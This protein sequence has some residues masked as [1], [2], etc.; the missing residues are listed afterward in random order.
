MT[1]VVAPST[2][3][4]AALALAEAQPDVRAAASALRQH[5][6]NARIVVVDAFD[7]RAEPKAAAGAKV[8]LWYGASDGHCWTVTTDPAQAAGLF[9]AAT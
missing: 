7:M 6:P 4:E 1:P 9:I 5:Y 2:P 8:S 3:I